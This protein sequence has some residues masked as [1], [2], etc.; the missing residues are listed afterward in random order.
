M[1]V[2]SYGAGVFTIESF[3]TP[4]ECSQYIQLSECI[5]F[6]ESEIVTPDGASMV[7]SVRNNDQIIFDDE[8]LAS[9]LLARAKSHL[10]QT[11][12]D[13]K[14]NGFNSRMRFYRYEPGQYFKWHR[15]NAYIVSETEESYL[16]FLM[17]LNEEYAGG[18]TEFKWD[19][20]QPKTGLAL[21]FPHELLH[22]GA[23]IESGVKY[24]LRTDVMYSLAG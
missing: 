5:G 2:Q 24:V 4:E 1:K 19:S 21:A 23:S 7:K 8:A 3:L 16:T 9:M 15:D 17:Y 14:L 18:A 12:G 6:E 11:M 20:I 22:Q 10:P 13:W